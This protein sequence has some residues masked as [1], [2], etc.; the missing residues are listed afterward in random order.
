MKRE[1]KYGWLSPDGEFFERYSN[2]ERWAGDY[3]TEHGLWDEYIKWDTFARGCGE[4]LVYVKR[5]VLLH[6]PCGKK[7]IVSCCGRRITKKR[8]DFLLT[9]FGN[10]DWLETV[11]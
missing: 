7:P 2:H 1:W 3:V 5:W 10:D 4:F 9:Y 11:H 6:N 8:N